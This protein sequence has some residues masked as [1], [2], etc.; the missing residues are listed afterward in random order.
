[1]D[2]QA[3]LQMDGGLGTRAV[4]CMAAVL[5]NLPLEGNQAAP[6]ELSNQAEID[7]LTGLRHLAVQYTVE[8]KVHLQK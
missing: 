6:V 3:V 1:M 7:I 8:V 2:M 5:G 4:W